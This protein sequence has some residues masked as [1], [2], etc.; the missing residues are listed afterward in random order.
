MSNLII[1]VV[2][3]FPAFPIAFYCFN[4]F[5][6]NEYINNQVENYANFDWN[7]ETKIALLANMT[8]M[9]SVYFLS[10]VFFISGCRFFLNPYPVNIKDPAIIEFGNRILQNSLEHTRSF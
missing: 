10:L 7:F 6:S 9:I 4:S 1:K 8:A 5:L 3:I 2:T